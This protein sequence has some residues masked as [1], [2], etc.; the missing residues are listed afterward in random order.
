MQLRLTETVD[1]E[2]PVE[3]DLHLTQGQF[4]LIGEGQNLDLAVMQDIR[5][6]LRMFKGEWFL[7]QS[8]GVPYFE[9]VL[10]KSPDLEIIKSIFRQVILGAK[11]VSA[12]EDL[13]VS[14]SDR[15]IQVDFSV[16]INSGLV[17]SSR[18]FEPFTV[19]L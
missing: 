14:L 19:V 3:G 8:E 10:V 13:S 5:S 2:N 18:D 7:D 11:Y 15:T 9:D 4:T 1:L 6:R 12:I 16:T 17:L